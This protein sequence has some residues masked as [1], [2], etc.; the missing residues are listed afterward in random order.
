MFLPW[1]L[2]G[3]RTDSG[4]QGV[5]PQ[6]E[7]LPHVKLG[8]DRPC[9]TVQEKT[10]VGSISLSLSP[11]VVESAA[12]VVWLRRQISDKAFLFTDTQQ[13]V[14]FVKARPLVIIGFFQVLSS[15]GRRWLF[16]W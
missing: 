8:K 9:Y 2:V 13:V 11:G 3:R 5:G 15:R 12:L 4:L 1:G 7:K 6:D 10:S 16:N 14:E